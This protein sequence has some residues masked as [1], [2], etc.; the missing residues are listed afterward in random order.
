MNL[1]SF[2]YVL[3]K[4]PNRIHARNFTSPKRGRIFLKRELLRAAFI[5]YK[6]IFRKNQAFPLIKLLIN[7]VFRVFILIHLL[8]IE[9]QKWP[10]SIRNTIYKNDLKLPVILQEA[11]ILRVKYAERQ[12]IQLLKY[13]KHVVFNFI[14][15]KNILKIVAEIFGNVICGNY[16]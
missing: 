11:K 6:P 2:P 15:K 10:K 8:M 14:S 9:E 7:A 5:K 16:L 1:F 4:N 13:L 12:L 3:N